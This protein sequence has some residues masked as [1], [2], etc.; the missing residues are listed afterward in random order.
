MPTYRMSSTGGNK[1]QSVC[2]S[3]QY[4]IRQL[5]LFLGET[6]NHFD[7]F[8]KIR[9]SRIERYV[10]ETNKL[11]IRLDK[12]IT[13]APK[14]P[15]KRKLHERTVVQWAND[16]DVRLCPSCA[17]SFNLSRRRHHCRLCGGIMCHNCSQF[18]DFEYARKN[19][20]V[21]LVIDWMIWSQ[22]KWSVRPIWRRATS[23]HCPRPICREEAAAAACSQSLTRAVTLTSEFAGIARFFWIEGINK[24]KTISLNLYCLNFMIKCVKVLK[25]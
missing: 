7:Y 8:R 15:E 9:D 18:L 13:D 22:A 5:V 3:I 14:D 1:C 25:K 24:S 16:D 20:L 19:Y 23:Q 4:H 10:I 21:R 17:K 6:R 11:L 2:N 12:L